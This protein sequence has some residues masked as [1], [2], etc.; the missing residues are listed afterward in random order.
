MSAAFG[1]LISTESLA[2]KL[3][4]PGNRLTFYRGMRAFCPCKQDLIFMPGLYSTV[5]KT[6]LLSG[7]VVGPEGFSA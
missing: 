2:E 7:H 6:V 5:P 1:N 4:R 3:A